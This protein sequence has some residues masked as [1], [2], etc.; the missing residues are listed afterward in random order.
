M[1]KQILA[2]AVAGAF[3]VPAI[4]SADTTLFGQFKYEVGFMD[5]GDDRNMVHSKR[6][7]RLG[8]D[9]KEDLGNGLTATARFQ[10][11]FG[12]SPNEPLPTQRWGLTENAWVGLTGDF[13]RL[14]IGRADTAVKEA[15][16][17]FRAF[18][19]TLADGGITMPANWW[20][21]EG[22]HYNSPSFGGTTIGVTIAPDGDKSNAYYALNVQYNQGPIR[23]TAAVE[24]FSDGTPGIPA[25]NLFV[26][27]IR[28][29]ETNYQVGA[30]YSFGPGNVGVLYQAINDGD[31]DVITVPFNFGVTSNVDLRA[32]VQHVDPDNGDS[33]TN[34]AVGA[35]YK[36][37]NRSDVWVNVWEDDAN[38]NTD[39]QFAVGMRHSF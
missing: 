25:G 6:G 5:D 37:S 31:T 17:G 18:S 15:S 23:V 12:G 38:D 14:R 21:A 36:F 27:G 10:G 20:R 8:I 19:D 9:V 35:I 22:I 33:H 24:D 26:D 30:R 7:T 28:E 4:A 3:A 39:V 16:K 11:N 13:G 29:D 1:K 32:A 2:I 34:V